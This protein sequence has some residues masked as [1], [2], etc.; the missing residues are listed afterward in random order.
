MG[1]LQQVAE[2]INS[3]KI[4]NV[5]VNVCFKNLYTN[6]QNSITNN[7]LIKKQLKT[8]VIDKFME[9]VELICRGQVNNSFMNLR[10]EFIELLIEI[11]SNCKLL[12]SEQYSKVDSESDFQEIETVIKKEVFG[13][14]SQLK[15]KLSCLIL[16]TTLDLKSFIYSEDQYLRGQTI[17]LGLLHT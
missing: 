12:I 13:L 11:K 5:Q 6:I 16:N 2:R 17:F 4:T 10:I 9:N 3:I 14:L 1:L 8:E 7:K 15:N